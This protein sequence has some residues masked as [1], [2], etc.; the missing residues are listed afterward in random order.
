MDIDRDGMIG[1]REF[2]MA[3]L[4]S[5]VFTVFVAEDGNG[6]ILNK[7]WAAGFDY[8]DE[9][10]DGNGKGLITREECI[11]RFGVID[12]NKNGKLSREEFSCEC[13]NLLD[14]DERVC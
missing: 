11:A 2:H 13:L 8:F 5:F 1:K 10:K 9:A 7:E 14:K 12:L 6:Y 4:H 3:T